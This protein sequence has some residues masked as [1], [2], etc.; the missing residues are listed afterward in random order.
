[1]SKVIYAATPFR[2]EYLRDQICNFIESKGHFPLHPLL[3]LPYERFNY[4]RHDRETIYRVCFGLV[5]LSDELWIFGIGGG[6]LKEWLHAKES[7]KPTSSFVKQFD[8]HW[9]EW[10]TKEKYRTKYATV[11]EEVLALSQ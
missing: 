11:L 2:M 4:E 10:S 9:K 1:M 8:P 7:G 3:T 5:D 6:S